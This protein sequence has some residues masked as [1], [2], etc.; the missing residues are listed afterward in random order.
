[1][2]ALLNKLVI[3]VSIGLQLFILFTVIR[4][5]LHRRFLWFELYII[6]ELCEAAVRFTVAGNK[7][8]YFNVYWL[9]AVGGVAFSV[10][11]IRESFLNV[12][13]AYTRLRWFVWFVWGC[14]G[15]AVLYAVFKAWVFPP[16]PA[17][18]RGAVIIGL[19]L[20]VDFTVA[21]IGLVYFGLVR[22]FRIRNHQ[23]E[24]GI[25][26]GFLIYAVFELL[27]LASR[28]I[29]GTRFK[30]A[31]EWVPAIAYIIAEIGWAVVLSRPERKIS[32]P[33]DLTV[34]DLAQL[35]QDSEFLARF[36]G[37]RS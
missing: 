14:I 24:S 3:A 21:V 35:D 15:L 16:T 29:Y 7:A 18:R 12:F 22:F 5:R 9:T 33:G 10:L 11:A 6:Y 23:W 1:M 31:R 2:D 19:Q 36:L 25:M 27:P 30:T 4:K 32:R 37:R 28:S 8:V 20:G 34:D 17:S 13:R 26:A